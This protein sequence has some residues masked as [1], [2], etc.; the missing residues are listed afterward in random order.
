LTVQRLC[1]QVRPA[2]LTP[3]ARAARLLAFAIALCLTDTVLIGACWHARKAA[4]AHAAAV[5][6]CRILSA[7]LELDD[8]VRPA[9][10]EAEPQLIEGVVDCGVTGGGR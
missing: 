6:G 8:R 1:R 10:T 2:Q 3:G 4:A 5:E 9:G 7:V